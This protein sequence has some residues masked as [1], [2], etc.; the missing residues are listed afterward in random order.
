MTTMIKSKLLTDSAW[1]DVL[2]K[3][4]GVKDNGLLKTLAEIKK[5]G[6]DDHD[7][8]LKALDELLKLTGQMKKSKEIAAVPLVGKYLT[9]LAAAAESTVREVAK[10][11]AEA[12]KK[13]KV[14]ADAAKKREQEESK[15]AKDEGEDEDEAAEALLT[16]KMIPL[17]RMVNKGEVLHTMVASTGKQ[18]VVL[19]ARKPIA[20]T[21]RKL[22]A[23]ELGS[24]GGIKY[25]EGH[26]LREKGMTTFVLKTQV[27]GLAKKIKLALLEQTGLRVKLCCRGE[28]G[29]IDDDLEEPDEVKDDE[30]GDEDD[31]RG[32][33][34]DRGA[35]AGGDGKAASPE[36]AQAPEVW[37]G[38]RDLIE[39]SI[40]SL[41]SAVQAQIA[42]EGAEVVAQIN[43]Q[44]QKLDR[45]LGRLDQ[46]LTS[47]L[48]TAGQ[49][50]GGAGR[51]D[52]LRESKAI[53][54][55]Y[56]RYVRSEPLIDHLDNNPFGVKTDIKA[57]LSASLTKLARA[58]G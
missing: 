4:K 36:L 24:A 17:L 43:G 42:D 57:T 30:R 48:A 26:C 29:D 34:D 8:A 12:E 45:I 22:L 2:A 10:A 35:G 6:E 18:V 33:G 53:L 9:E 23:E 16:T 27:T 46:R 51:S 28:D 5:L 47:S 3:N 54:A 38:T 15:G 7:D 11:K 13:L 20:H 37:D 50:S 44:L 40:D 39:T 19:L 1:K 14:E 56:I 49:A 55:E 58:I 41:K 21:R 52:A 25:F 31:K 32:K